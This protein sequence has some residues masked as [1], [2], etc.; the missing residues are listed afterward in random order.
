MLKIK[1]ISK[2][3]TKV[4]AIVILALNF[5]VN[6][7]EWKGVDRSGQNHTVTSRAD[8]SVALPHYKT[9]CTS[10]WVDT[11]SHGTN[12]KE[13]TTCVQELIGYW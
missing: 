13:V 5:Q 8:T 9:V 3:Q 11:S 2:I 10:R 7:N 1:Q 6:A 12:Q 4:L